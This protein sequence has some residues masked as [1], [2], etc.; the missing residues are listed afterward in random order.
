MCVMDSLS[1]LILVERVLQ[2]GGQLSVE[3]SGKLLCPR[4]IGERHDQTFEVGQQVRGADVVHVELHH[5]D[6][7]QHDG[8]DLSVQVLHVDAW[9]L[10]DN[11][12][13]W[14]FF[15]TSF[16]FLFNYR[17]TAIHQKQ[18]NIEN[19]SITIDCILP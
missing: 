18:N 11:S 3:E 8:L 2:Y 9:I 15:I 5:R 17:L 4:L 10:T 12:L 13:L 19:T 6:S 1:A 7:L 14:V 16:K